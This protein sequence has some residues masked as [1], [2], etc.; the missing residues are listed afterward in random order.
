MKEPFRPRTDVAQPVRIFDALLG[1]CDNFSVD[2]DAA[3]EL[4]SSVP[5]GAGTIQLVL[6][7]LI[8]FRCR[9]VRHLMTEEGLRQFL[10][11][12]ASLPLD[13]MTHEIAQKIAPDSRVVYCVDDPDTLARAHEIEGQPRDIVGFIPIDL[14][15]PEEI[16]T[17]AARTLDLSLPVAVLISALSDIPNSEDPWQSVATIVDGLPSGS[18]LVVVQVAK[19]ISPE[20][21]AP[22]G[23]RYKDLQAQGRM[24]PLAFRSQEDVERFFDGLELVKPGVVPVNHW[25]PRSGTPT[26]PDEH[27]PP[28]YG[29]VGHK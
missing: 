7:A 21:F 14:Q 28:F 2:R 5:G 13:R 20:R 9:V 12:G 22:A 27:T 16:L 11:V 25:R 29:A 8:D 4:S 19:D 6:Q 15:R 23:K 26:L 10:H 18:F 17:Q 1:G 24:R 3:G